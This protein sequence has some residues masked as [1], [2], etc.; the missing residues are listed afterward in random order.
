MEPTEDSFQPSPTLPQAGGSL[1]W[2]LFCLR[3]AL[4]AS[5][6]VTQ[7]PVF[8]ERTALPAD[9]GLCVSK[10]L[11]LSATGLGRKTTRLTPVLVMA[12]P[13]TSLW[14]STTEGA[15]RA[16]W[17]GWPGRCLS[18]TDNRNGSLSWLGTG[19][20]G[21]NL[22]LINGPGTNEAVPTGGQLFLWAQQVSTWPRKVVTPGGG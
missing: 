19:T 16:G 2:E 11:V 14:E 9:Q 4:T 21:P 22:S 18:I 3:R 1:P 10:S 15:H 8:S 12:V 13:H 6:Q 5:H 7:E 20:D 17:R